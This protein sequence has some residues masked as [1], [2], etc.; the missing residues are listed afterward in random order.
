MTVEKVCLE[1]RPAKSLL[2]C[3][4]SKLNRV[5]WN[6]ESFMTIS[7]LSS[8]LGLTSLCQTLYDVLEIQ[9]WHTGFT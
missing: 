4:P 5:I 2:F 6:T 1:D 3:V 8:Q 9:F 7:L